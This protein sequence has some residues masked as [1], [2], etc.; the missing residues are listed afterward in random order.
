MDQDDDK[1]VL[2]IMIMNV[3]L[4]FVNNSLPLKFGENILKTFDEVNGFLKPIRL[5]DP[6]VPNA[7]F[8]YPL[9]TSENLNFF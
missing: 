4:L 5:L 3:V 6:F 7:P 8:L 1:C 2:M 9:K